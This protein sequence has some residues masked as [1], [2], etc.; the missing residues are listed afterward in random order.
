VVY[1]LASVRYMPL[2][3]S[4][5][6]HPAATASPS[7][8]D[9]V[10]QSRWIVHRYHLALVC[11]WHHRDV[12]SKHVAESWFGLLVALADQDGVFRSSLMVTL[13]STLNNIVFL[14]GPKFAAG[15]AR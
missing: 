3:F 12:E 13:G 2:Y 11:K 6:L 4:P 9:K 1:L 14:L 7:A 10:T 5:H 15:A 8:S